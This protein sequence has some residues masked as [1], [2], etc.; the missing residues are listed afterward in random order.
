MKKTW[1]RSSRPEKLRDVH[2]HSGATRAPKRTGMH[3]II[4]L[5]SLS[6]SSGELR[7]EIDLKASKE[8]NTR[9]G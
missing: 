9:G 8:T 5:I 3:G 2:F 4:A 6:F 7:S 1:G